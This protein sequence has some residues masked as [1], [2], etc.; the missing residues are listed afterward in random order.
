MSV[1]NYSVMCL[2]NCQSHCVNVDPGLV[3]EINPRQE[4]TDG[5]PY[6]TLVYANGPGPGREQNLTLENTSESVKEGY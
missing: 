2:S 1:V 5:N 4:P 3:D 6:T